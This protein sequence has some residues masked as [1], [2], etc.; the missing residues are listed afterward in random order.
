MTMTTRRDVFKFAGAAGLAAAVPVS[1]ALPPVSNRQS[2][3]ARKG[4]KDGFVPESESLRWVAAA[5]FVAADLRYDD[6][7]A[8]MEQLAGGR[9]AVGRDQERERCRRVLTTML[10]RLD[11][12]R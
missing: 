12:V 3:R 1:P 6:Q 5:V 11:D 2:A 4:D 8:V 10:A 7:A 9:I